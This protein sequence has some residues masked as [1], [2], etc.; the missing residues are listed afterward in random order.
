M[1][2]F[3]CFIGVK[4]G[5]TTKK[6]DEPLIFLAGPYIDLIVTVNYTNIATDFPR[7]C[8]NVILFI[9]NPNQSV[10]GLIESDHYAIYIFQNFK[11]DLENNLGHN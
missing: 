1:K 11:F 9:S 7:C 4:I 5:P 3:W 10:I 8:D 2:L 6:V